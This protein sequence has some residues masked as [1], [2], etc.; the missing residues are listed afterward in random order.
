MAPQMEPYP[1]AIFQ[2]IVVL[3]NRSA[4]SPSSA[5]ALSRRIGCAFGSKRSIL[6]D[7]SIPPQD[8]V[9]FSGSIFAHSK[10]NVLKFHKS[11]TDPACEDRQAFSHARDG[12]RATQP[13][14]L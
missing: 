3:R 14:S 4:P 9:L 12:V 7:G 5:W 10:D 2:Q 8:A 11:A 13:R 1:D 6:R